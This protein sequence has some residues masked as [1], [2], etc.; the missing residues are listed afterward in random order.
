MRCHPLD[1]LINLHD[2]YRRRFKI[3]ALDIL[4]VQQGE[5]RYLL[6]AQCPHKSHSLESAHVDERSIECPL[7]H[8]RFSLADGLVI[9]S[10]EQPCRALRT[11][12]LVY[13]GN[14]VGLMLGD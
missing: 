8:Y 14:E 2:G 10:G 5:Q 9:A 1:K 6:E 13:E 7:H 12:E 11:Y 4:L 3:D